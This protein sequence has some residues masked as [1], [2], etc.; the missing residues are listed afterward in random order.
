M[1]VLRTNGMTDPWLQTLKGNFS[2]RAQT[3]EIEYHLYCLPEPT[4]AFPDS[5]PHSEYSPSKD[6][7]FYRGCSSNTQHSASPGLT[8]CPGLSILIQASRCLSPATPTLSGCS[9]HARTHCSHFSFSLHFWLQE[10]FEL[11]SSIQPCLKGDLFYWIQNFWLLWS[12]M[13]FGLFSLPYT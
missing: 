11:S 3:T 8:F 10:L 5:F 12:Y 1:E 6:Q 2:P 9:I 13:V 7:D 4:G